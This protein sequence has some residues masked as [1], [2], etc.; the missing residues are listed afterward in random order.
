[1][2]II[3]YS[4]FRLPNSENWLFYT[5]L[6][7][8]VWNIKM[9]KLI[10][11]DWQNHIEV[12]SKTFSDYDNIFYGLKDLYGCSLS[13]NEQ[14]PLCKGMLTRLKPIF[15]QNLEY[16]L[17]R[18]A[19][20]LTTY[21]EAVAVNKW[22]ETQETIFT[23]KDNPG[24]T[25]EIMGGLT[26]FKCEPLKNKYSTWDGLL[27]RNKSELSIHGADQNFLM[28]NVLPDFKNEVSVV[29]MRGVFVYD[30]VKLPNVNPDLWVSNLCVSFIGAAGVNNM[31]T[32][33]FMN[34]FAS[35]PEFEEI[36]KKYKEIFYWYL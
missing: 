35:N 31:E 6:R 27:A 13:M 36:E 26:G 29:D 2:K 8:L 10:Y 22:M 16:V 20:A 33:R 34:R 7:G 14:M 30:K 21:R 1:M 28:Q 25:L 15:T 4:I 32:I 18:D 3:S 17:C 19:D 23:I 5:Y 11:P 12:D 24:H 9:N